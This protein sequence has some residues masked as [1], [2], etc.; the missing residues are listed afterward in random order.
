MED[1]R[2]KVIFSGVY[3]PALEEWLAR[4]WE[5]VEKRVEREDFGLWRCAACRWLYKEKEQATPFESLPDDW[6]CPVCFAGKDAFEKV[7]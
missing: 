7:G 5:L 3:P 1:A 2:D 4:G 6:K